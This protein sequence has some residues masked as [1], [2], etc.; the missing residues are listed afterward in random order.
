MM[1]EAAMKQLQQD[2][3][4]AYFRAKSLPVLAGV[5]HAGGEA[6]DLRG[7]CHLPHR[8]CL[9]RLSSHEAGRDEQCPH[10]YRYGHSSTR[11]TK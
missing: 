5:L 3:D 1:N 6:P 2:E 11:V 7:Y 8:P 4:M 9:A 10:L